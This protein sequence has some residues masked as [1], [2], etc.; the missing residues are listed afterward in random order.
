MFRCSNSLYGNM[1]TRKFSDV[2]QTSDAFVQKFQEIGFDLNV[3]QD[4]TN[5]L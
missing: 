3:M 5:T 4:G 2:F 1:R